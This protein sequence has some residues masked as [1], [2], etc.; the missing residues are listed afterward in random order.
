MVKR[1]L[2]LSLASVYLLVMFACGGDNDSTPPEVQAPA[3]A[4]PDTPVVSTPEETPDTTKTPEPQPDNT[5]VTD[6]PVKAT[7]EVIIS[8]VYTR[9]SGAA[10]NQHAVWIE[11]M[12]GGL[13]KSLFASRWTAEGGYVT[14]PDSIVIWATRAGLASMTS[15]EVDA[16]SGAT[17]RTGPQSYVW[18]L[19]DT[20][21]DTVM[22]GD[23]MIFVEGTLRWKNLVLYSG[24]I[25]IGNES[26]TIQAD[27]EFHYEESGRYAALTDDSPE[28][29]MIGSVTVEF[30]P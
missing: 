27:P 24:V 21:G 22:Q 7:G 15:A 25:T 5:D 18:D 16:V 10:S 14:R 11:D 12:D 13:V 8:F 9:Q 29:N 19:T 17:P 2:V 4:T 28:N 23:Y 6:T 1:V 3:T 26:V 20:N 30:L